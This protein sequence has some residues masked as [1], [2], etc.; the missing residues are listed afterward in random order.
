MGYKFNP[1]E[2]NSFLQYLD[3]NNLYGWAMSQLHPTG[4][5]NWVDDDD[6]SKLTPGEIA[7]LA[8]DDSKGYLLEVDVRYPKELHNL[9]NN[10][11]F[12]CKKKKINRMGCA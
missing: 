10:F 7:G 2:D 9:H 4:G 12:M 8:E 11:P 1:K 3:T 5:F 6:V